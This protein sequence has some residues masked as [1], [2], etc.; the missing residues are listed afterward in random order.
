MGKGK[1]NISDVQ[2]KPKK[3]PRLQKDLSTKKEKQS[4]E[5]VR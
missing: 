3:I 5:V 4:I 1:S 2:K